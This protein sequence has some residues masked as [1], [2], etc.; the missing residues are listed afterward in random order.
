LFGGNCRDFARS[1]F[2][3]SDR[4]QS[5]TEIKHNRRKLCEVLAR[6]AGQPFGGCLIQSA[7]DLPSGDRRYCG[8]RVRLSAPVPPPSVQRNAT[9]R[10]IRGSPASCA[11]VL[12]RRI[13]GLYLLSRD[14]LKYAAWPA[15]R[16]YRP[17][18]SAETKQRFASAAAR[19][20][21]SE[22]ALLK[23]LIEQMLAI[24]A[25]DEEAPPAPAPFATLASRF[26]L[27]P[28]TRHCCASVPPPGRCRRRLTSRRWSAP[29]S[30]R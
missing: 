17:W 13:W 29:I 10:R 21:L 18:V 30:G 14:G 23:R 25:G 16:T 7:S 27:S 4:S 26:G 11:T 5:F 2:N 1:L 8:R 12:F 3:A 22:S 28:M 6:I 9:R 19:Q 20:G 24:G 15:A